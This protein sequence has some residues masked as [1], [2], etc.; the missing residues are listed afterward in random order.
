ML[1]RSLSDR[2]VLAPA[3]WL[4]AAVLAAACSPIPPEHDPYTTAPRGEVG[5]PVLELRWKR[6]ISERI[7]ESKP[8]EFA[9]P[10]VYGEL[11]FIGSDDGIFYAMSTR[12][13]AELWR[14]RLGAVS[15]RP[16]VD[17]LRGLIYVGTDD[18]A[19]ICLSAADGTERWRYRTRGPVLQQPVLV[20]GL[21]IFSNE[22]D[23]VYALD[24]DTGKY[25][26]Q[27]KGETP[28][29]YTLRGHSGV[30]VDNGLVFTGF[31]NGAM[32]AL[33]QS[34]GSVAWLTAFKGEADR[35]VDVDGTPEVSGDTVYVTSSSGGL[36]ALDKDTGSIRWRLPLEGAGSFVVSRDWIYVGAA[37]QGI[38][39][40]DRAGNIVWRQ[41]T[42]GGGEF[43][44]PVVS[45]D[46]LIYAL[47]ED[48]MF[49]ANR[50]T[51]KL[52]QYFDPGDGISAAPAVDGDQLY[53]LSNRGILYA[54]YLD[55]F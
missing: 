39:A 55:R 15:S 41:G 18:G 2:A 26:W 4:L 17:T 37:E 5:L 52:F 8:Q 11:L 6:A 33:R 50:R 9:T 49:I 51:G 32:V 7:N 14:Q 43:A 45:G 12:N 13:G 35:F 22:A 48:G 19:L 20:D 34:T 42:R 1:G 21:I 38:H 16:L 54:M 3:L 24:S 44:P 29:E 30:K 47:S 36:F 10:A 27:Y 46:Y 31:S 53:V 23:Q 25:R 28:D 40:V